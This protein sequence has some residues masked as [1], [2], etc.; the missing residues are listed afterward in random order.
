MRAIFV[1]LLA[2]LFWTSAPAHAATQIVDSNGQLTGASGINI[3]GTRYD[4]VFRD[5]T[6]LDLFSSCDGPG[7]FDF[8]DS[9]TARLAAEALLAQV[10]VDSALGTFGND[11]ELIFGCESDAVCSI[12][13]PYDRFVTGSGQVSSNHLFARALVFGT[14][15]DNRTDTG[16]GRLVTADSSSSSTQVFALFSV[17]AVPEPATW[18][19]MIFGL[20]FVGGAMRRRNSTNV[21]TPAIA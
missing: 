11:P 1:S 7:D 8:T 19:M 14:A 9:A 13:I 12:E 15:S 21:T 16:L 6:C 2:V 4:V 18:L 20:G 5:G 10:F 17:S 3:D